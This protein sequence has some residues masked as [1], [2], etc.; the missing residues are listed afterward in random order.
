[1]TA[2]QTAEN[3]QHSGRAYANES[4]SCHHHNQF[5]AEILKAQEEQ[6]ENLTKQMAELLKISRAQL[7]KKKEPEKRSVATMTDQASEPVASEVI[8]KDW[9]RDRVLRKD[10]TN[11]CCSSS[12][13]DFHSGSLLLSF[14]K[15]SKDS[16]DEVVYDKILREVESRLSQ[17]RSDLH[18]GR[19]RA[20]LTSRYPSPQRGEPGFP[21]YPN[22]YSPS[23]ESVIINQLAEKYLKD[24]YREKAG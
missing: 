5:F 7:K 4:C 13:S 11:E 21:R 24:N 22:R 12:D 17:S 3:G 18:Y 15:S 19:S 10:G 20:R 9:R 16:D 6:L 1:M 2:A 8:R 14:E 23:Q